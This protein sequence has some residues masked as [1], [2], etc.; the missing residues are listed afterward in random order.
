M[1]PET[2]LSHMSLQFLSLE[3]DA[4]GIA[5]L[6]VR[7]PEKRNALNAAV[8]E[9]LSDVFHRAQT[10]PAVKAIL[11][12][13]EGDKAFI[14]G[15]DI[16]EVAAASPLDSERL[17]RRGQQVFRLLETMRKP[18]VAAINGF[19][20]GGGLE[21]ALCATVRMASVNAK[22]GL[23]EVKLGVIPGYGGT[24]RLPRLI[25]RGRAMQWM[26]SG[27]TIDAT[28]AY[29]IG[30]VNAVCEP[31]RLIETS[32]AWLSRVLANSPLAV[33]TA[34]EAVDIGF[35]VGLEAGL[36]FESTAFGL[37]AAS[38]DRREGTQ[39]FLEKRKANFT[40]K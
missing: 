5:L 9:E 20:L 4:E 16:A 33:G 19:A 35:E 10:D 26:L 32:R 8:I 22:M 2:R 17:S 31:E 30:L 36:H 29:R 13:G 18:S 28:E 21:L 25:G 37:V 3:L 40:G 23:P 38:D 6:T 34:M 11:L 7:R 24:Q 39:A 12:T 1:L 27:D 14:A 15:A